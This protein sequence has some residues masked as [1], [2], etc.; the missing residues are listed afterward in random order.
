MA[1]TTTLHRQ[2]DQNTGRMVA[3]GRMENGTRQ[4]CWIHWYPTGECRALGVYDDDVEVGLWSY[5]YKNGQKA[6]EGVYAQG[7]E[8]GEWRYW[9]ENGVLKAEGTYNSGQIT[10]R[11]N[12]RTVEDSIQCAEQWEGGKL[13]RRLRPVPRALQLATA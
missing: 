3:E 12:R 10:G 7:K 5:W 13:V 11:W 2:Y 4:G 8:E 9:Y 6:A 1:S